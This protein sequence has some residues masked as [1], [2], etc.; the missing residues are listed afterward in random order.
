MTESTERFTVLILSVLLGILISFTSLSGFMTPDFYEAES[1]NWQVQSIG[2]D[3]I[4]VFIILPFLLTSAYYVYKGSLNALL[5]WAGAIL[6]IIYTYVIYCFNV[7]FNVFFL[8]YCFI[9]G[10]S[11]YVLLYIIYSKINSYSSND[12]R[13]WINKITALYFIILS[14]LFYILW[15]SE[16]IPSVLTHSVPKTIT[17]A[18]LFT[19]PVHVLDL[20][21]LLPGIFITGILLFKQKR[22]AWF[23]APLILTFLLLMDITIAL[24]TLVMVDKGVSD[25]IFVAYI[26]IGLAVVSVILLAVNLKNNKQL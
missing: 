11:I 23:L 9:L 12:S 7:H 13:R 1:L 10:L 2:Q 24:L 19:N 22:T 14:V 20:S 8:Q 17:D 4:N 3:L 25:D 21:V 6:Y 16:I 5:L 15:L 18:G 26:M